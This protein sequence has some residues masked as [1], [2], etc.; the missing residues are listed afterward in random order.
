MSSSSGSKRELLRRDEEEE[1]RAEEEEE[2]GSRE[3][4]AG[5]VAGEEKESGSGAKGED[6]RDKGSE[7]VVSV[8]IRGAEGETRG[9]GA[10]KVEAQLPPPSFPSFGFPAPHLDQQNPPN[11]QRTSS[12]ELT[13][14][15][16]SRFSTC[17]GPSRSVVS[18]DPSSSLSFLS[19]SFINAR[20]L[21]FL[22][23][24]LRIDEPTE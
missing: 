17:E 1:E 23:A 6:C 24:G 7:G 20:S 8:S 22:L 10:Q 19:S 16:P 21:R 2:E 18:V 11:L 3:E 14:S 4:E 9:R 13:V 15:L 5:G 12:H